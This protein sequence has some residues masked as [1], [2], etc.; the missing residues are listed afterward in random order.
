MK[1][2][3]VRLCSTWEQEEI[4]GEHSEFVYEIVPMQDTV[5]LHRRFFLRVRGF[6]KQGPCLSHDVGKFVI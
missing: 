6:N 4:D 1:Q 5:E 3:E 2:E